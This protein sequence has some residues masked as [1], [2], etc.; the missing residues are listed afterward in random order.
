M[1][2]CNGFV[3]LFKE[4]WGAAVGRYFW[5]RLRCVRLVCATADHLRTVCPVRVINVSPSALRSP[6]NKI[7]RNAIQNHR[8]Y[9]KKRNSS[10][11]TVNS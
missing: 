1:H 5:H 10:G 7:S 6:P 4:K 2:R 8:T 9:H 11:A 3:F